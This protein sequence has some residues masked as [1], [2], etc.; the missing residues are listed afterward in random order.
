M[1]V[2][3][4]LMHWGWGNF[5]YHRQRSGFQEASSFGGSIWPLALSGIGWYCFLGL[6][7]LLH[8]GPEMCEMLVAS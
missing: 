1:K 2:L 5:K 8:P 7:D 4:H 3:L 6:P